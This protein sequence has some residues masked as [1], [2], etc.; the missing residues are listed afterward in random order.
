MKGFKLPNGFLI[1][2]SNKSFK[3]SFVFQDHIFPL[4][5]IVWNYRS[6]FDENLL[7]EFDEL[8]NFL[9]YCRNEFKNIETDFPSKSIGLLENYF[10]L[11]KLN[12]DNYFTYAKAIIAKGGTGKSYL[13]NT[14]NN[15]EVSKD[16]KKIIQ[17]IFDKEDVI[18]FNSNPNKCFETYK[19]SLDVQYK[20]EELFKSLNI[21][22]NFSL[23]SE[24]NFSN[25][26]KCNLNL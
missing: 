26:P 12:S 13:A 11:E 23:Y 10:G 1:D 8:G 20:A 2:F 22:D 21:K 5:Q 16:N 25:L 18:A 14:V 6:Q 3:Q 4:G 15:F 24:G 9:I 17:G 7:N 19:E